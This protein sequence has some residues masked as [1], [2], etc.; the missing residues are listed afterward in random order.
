M[1]IRFLSKMVK[2]ELAFLVPKALLID[3][4]VFLAALPFFGLDTGIPLG[5]LIGTAA[6]TVNIAVLGYATERTV[7][8]PLKQAKRYMFSFYLLRMVFLGAVI[9]AG[10]KFEFLNPAAVYLPLLYPKPIHTAD[11]VLKARKGG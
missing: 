9:V 8:R 4:V 11:A 5:L 3:L 6:M 10:F 2:D 1:R 7:E